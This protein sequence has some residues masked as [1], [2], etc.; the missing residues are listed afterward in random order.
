MSDDLGQI[1]LSIQRTQQNLLNRIQRL[2]EGRRTDNARDWGT[3]HTGY[4]VCTITEPPTTTIR[5]KSGWVWAYALY[6]ND[7]VQVGPRAWPETLVDLTDHASSFTTAYY[8]RWC[9]VAQNLRTNAWGIWEPSDEFEDAEVA[10]RHFYSEVSGCNID[11]TDIWGDPIAFPHCVLLLKNNGTTGV[12]GEIEKITLNDRN[13][14][15]F[16]QQDARP[17]MNMA[18]DYVC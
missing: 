7:I 14:S 13:Y 2:E 3:P 9:V 1:L 18:V 17:W 12:A 10:S 11:L 6:N 8:Y 5:I 4:G 15:S 16:L